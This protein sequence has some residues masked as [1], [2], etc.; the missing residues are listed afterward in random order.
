MFEFLDDKEKGEVSDF[1]NPY[2]AL[3]VALGFANA[4]QITFGENRTEC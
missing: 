4:T 3:E 2:A 1:M